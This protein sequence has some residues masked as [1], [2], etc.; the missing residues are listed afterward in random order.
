MCVC[1]ENACFCLLFIYIFLF[2]GDSSKVRNFE[3]K[4][5]TI[6]IISAAS[7]FQEEFNTKDA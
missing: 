4:I 3:K 7:L 1:D 6:F 2:M 5:P